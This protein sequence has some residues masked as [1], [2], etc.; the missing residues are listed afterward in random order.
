MSD[1]DF[2]DWRD[3]EFAHGDMT[4][5]R[6]TT[7]RLSGATFLACELNEVVLR[8]AEMVDTTGDGKIQSLAS[9]GVGAAPSLEACW[10]AGIPTAP[11]SDRRTPRGSGRPG[12]STSG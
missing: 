5:A 6:F 3:K 1:R 12:T 4:G 11:S 8:G 10:I 7:V 9:N 2:A